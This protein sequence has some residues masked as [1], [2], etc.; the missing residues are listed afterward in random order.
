MIEI[1]SAIG[2]AFTVSFITFVI[3]SHKAGMRVERRLTRVETKLDMVLE[4]NGLKC[5]E[6]NEV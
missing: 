6:K 4:S 2:G 3:A 1:M 5:E